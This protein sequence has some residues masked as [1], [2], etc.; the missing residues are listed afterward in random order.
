MVLG[1][2]FEYFSE[3]QISYHQKVEAVNCAQNKRPANEK[4]KKTSKC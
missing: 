4:N 2:K 1:Y 3:M